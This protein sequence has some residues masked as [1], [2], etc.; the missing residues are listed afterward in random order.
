MDVGDAREGRDVKPEPHFTSLGA[1]GY[2]ASSQ[3]PHAFNCPRKGS[4]AW[5]E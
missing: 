5:I 3:P 2:Y 4:R 1:F